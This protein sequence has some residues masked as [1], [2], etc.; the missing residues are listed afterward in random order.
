MKRL[1]S[2]ALAAV[3]ALSS[4][5]V[6]MTAS[7]QDDDHDHGHG[8]HRGHDRD[9]DGDRDRGDWRRDGDHDRGDWR[10]DNDNRGWDRGRHNGYSWNGRWFYGPPPAAYYG[11]PGYYPG[12]R[13]WRRGDYLPGYYR[14]EYR[15]VDWRYY[16]LR[17]PP[18]G[19]H[20]VRDDRGE[21]LLVGLATGLI[22]GAILSSDY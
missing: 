7:A 12:Y 18:R 5:A 13:S 10:R 17:P 11:R 1:S 15:D 8:W 3:T 20:W 2:L 22:L 4:V 19:Y 14:S 6:P 16:R 21:F 9:R